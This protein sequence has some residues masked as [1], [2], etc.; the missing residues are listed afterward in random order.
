MIISNS[1]YGNV[2]LI[3]EKV[4]FEITTFR[5]ELKYKDHRRPEKTFYVNSLDEDLK[6]RDFTINTL[7]IDKNGK[8]IDLMRAKDD[9]DNKIIRMVGNPKTRLK[10]DA[11]R[12][13]RAVRFATVLNFKIEDN[14]KGCIKRYGHYLRKLSSDRKKEELDIIFA[15][16]N[17]E[18]GIE[19]L[20]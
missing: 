19:L 15:S 5:K 7:C 17:K 4:R 16:N 2:S 9:L 20:N 11:L 8:E 6:R 18:Y 12:I 1:E 3:F 13:L 14:L 10:E